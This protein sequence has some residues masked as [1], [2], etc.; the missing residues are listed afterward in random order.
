MTAALALAEWM[1]RRCEGGAA[2]EMALLLPALLLLLLGTMEVGRMAWVQAGLNYA[3]G[4]AARCA[5]VRPDVCA[6]PQLTAAYAAARVVGQ[7]VPSSAFTVSN[8]PCGV[9]VSAQLPFTFILIPLTPSA[10]VLTA[11]L[12]RS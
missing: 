5:S 2:V 11:Q 6:T 8:Q 1:R 10:P 7:T 4:E 9:Q 12:C 3:V